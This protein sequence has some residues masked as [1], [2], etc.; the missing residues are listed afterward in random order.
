MEITKLLGANASLEKLSY[1]PRGMKPVGTCTNPE[2]GKKF[3]VFEIPEKRSRVSGFLSRIESYQDTHYM[4]RLK[5]D[6]FSFD[7][8][9]FLSILGVDIENKEELLAFTLGAYAHRMLGESPSPK[10]FSQA[11][12]NLERAGREEAR[13]K[14]IR[15]IVGSKSTES[16]SRNIAR[17]IRLMA[18]SKESFTI[19]KFIE[20]LLY[21]DTAKL[22]N[23]LISE[24]YSSTYSEEE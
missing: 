6:P 11:L 1:T 5:K 4:S 24:F 17:V 23:S 21:K 9:G 8:M 20:D 18:S 12:Y 22:N 14:N 3:V 16:R 10:S 19:K 13:E 15:I 2:T 7:S